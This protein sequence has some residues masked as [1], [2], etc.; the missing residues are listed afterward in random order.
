M[1]ILDKAIGALTP[2]ESEQARSD[3]RAKARA[4]A[5]PGDWLSLVLSHHQEIETAFAAVKN[6]GDAASRTAAQK[7]LG[8]V[9]TGHSIAEESVLYP[10]LAEADEKGHATMAYTEQAAAKMQM[11]ALENLDPMSQDYLDKLE[12]IKGA[13]AHHVYEEEGAWFIELKERASA[14]V[15]QKLTQR[16]KEE[17]KRYVGSDDAGERASA[18]R[19]ARSWEEASFSEEERRAD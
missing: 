1:S 16:Y 2:P 14:D 9:L 12:H 18:P 15:Q 10:A 11:A 5:E 6:A 8:I 19:E 13:V 3:A 7:A 17:F 4:A